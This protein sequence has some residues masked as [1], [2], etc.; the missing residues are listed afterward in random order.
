VKKGFLFLLP[1]LFLSACA[2]PQK[3]V[4]IQWPA[5]VTYLQ[6]EGDLTLSWRKEKYAGPFSLMMDYPDKFILEVYGAFGQ[7]LVYVKKEGDS[8][9]F[10][11]G[12]EKSTNEVPFEEA[13]GLTVRQLMDDL[14]MK[15]ER[16]ETPDGLVIRR[17]GYRV[18]YT[19]DRGRRRTCWEG[20]EGR[21][22]LTF[23]EIRFVK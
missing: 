22:C 2:L 14:A 13:Y 7:T 3:R 11:A 1:L 18:V 20:R 12:D 19:Q 9:L 23:D 6:G 17:G 10:M 16:Q 15:G 21:I 4:E 5:D 8:F